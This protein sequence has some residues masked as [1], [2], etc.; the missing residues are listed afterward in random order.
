[1]SDA[2]EGDGERATGSGGRVDAASQA[3]G[4]AAGCLS[5][6]PL[7]ALGLVLLLL[8]VAIHGISSPAPEDTLQDDES[9]E[10]ARIT[11]EEFGL[12]WD[13]GFVAVF[14]D[15]AGGE[16]DA[17]LRAVETA[18]ESLP[19]ITEV[20]TPFDVPGMRDLSLSEAAE[21]PLVVAAFMGEGGTL[22]PY[23]YA[24]DLTEVPPD[25]WFEQTT[26]T[27]RAAVREASPSGALDVGLA[28]LSTV[29]EAQGRAFESERWRFMGFGALL[30]F[31][32]ASGAFRN[33]R[34]TFLAGLPPLVGVVLSIGLARAVGLGADGFTT[35]VLPLL[36]L[37]IG[38]AD[39]LHIVVAM[40]KA[41][42]DGAESGGSAA[43]MAIRT[44]AWPCLLTSLTTAIGFASLA[45]AGH[46]L[47]VEFG[48]SC[49]LSTAV[50]FVTVILV[51]PLLARTPLGARLEDIK[52]PQFEGDERAKG[53]VVRLIDRMI[54]ATLRT[55]RTV[56]ILGVGLTAASVWVAAGI[57]ADRMVM[58]D[59]ADGSEAATTLG[60]VDAELGGVFPVQVRIDWEEG[61][62]ARDLLEASSTA[63]EILESEP[64]I[65]GALGPATLLGALPGDLPWVSLALVPER[66]RRSFVD[67]DE[68]RALVS[69]R[70]QDA[71]SRAL[72]PAFERVRKRL[73]EASSDSIELQLV[74]D[75]VAY[76]ETVDDVTRDLGRSLALAAILILITLAL[77]F[78][79]WRLGLASMVPNLLPLGVS[80]A[81]LRFSGGH[82]DVSTLTALTLSLGIATD[83]TIHV[84][85]RWERTRAVMKRAS[86]AARAAVLR[87]LPALTMTTLTL[88]AAFGQLLTS[89][90]PTIR[91]FG[92]LA[93]ITLVVAFLADALLL[94]AILVVLDRRG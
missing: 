30:G 11:R 52:P 41:R 17:A 5:D 65:A 85:A 48:L 94:P 47:V 68:R 63:E 26:A 86:E 18:V 20:T 69:G 23:E 15:L 16:A 73:A 77:A 45:T 88:T 67:L 13:A 12:N 50:T 58:T 75:H 8:G 3:V 56:A 84:L 19:W 70:I 14:G 43:T 38:F 83:D 71:G 9:W 34:A 64:L 82:V 66:W 39:S 92:L 46:T 59:L 54:S 28:G 10:T 49:A 32:I 37:T 79:S 61:A 4:R 25:D 21:N 36:V 76:L 27:A 80:A 1:M 51:I 87:T 53:P 7:W 62:D 2:V 89:A 55:P 60:R 44:L 91:D 72:I 35:I 93:G 24:S 29:V 31:L 74:G 33:V 22:L 57:Q 90:L 78:R 40:A 6:R 42:A 81:G